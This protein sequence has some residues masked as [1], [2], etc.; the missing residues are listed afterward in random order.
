MI[1]CN[2][3]GF[4]HLTFEELGACK[5]WGEKVAECVAQGHPIVRREWH[6]GSLEYCTCGQKSEPRV[7]VETT[8]KGVKQP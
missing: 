8:P 3:C 5:S 4:G 2:K 7:L 1:S 6:F